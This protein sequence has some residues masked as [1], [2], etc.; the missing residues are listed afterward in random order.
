MEQAIEYFGFITGLLYLFW[1]IRQNNLMWVVG[2]LS[3]M[4]Y[5]AVFAQSGLYAAMSFQVYYLVVSIYGLYV[6]HR[7]KKRGKVSENENENEEA[8]NN[9]VYRVLDWKMV[10]ASTSASLAIF[11]LLYIVL[12]KFTGDPMPAADAVITA[13]SI[14]ATYWLGRLYIHQWILWIVVDL[15]SVF[16]FFSQALYPT[17]LL[18]VLYTVCA[19]YGFVHW[20]EKGIKL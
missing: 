1:E 10:L 4:A 3:A 16:L 7:D 15:L 2:I 18:Y 13:L 19:V 11:F 6:W 5:I 20:K 17:A 12:E 8:C 9:L 14:V